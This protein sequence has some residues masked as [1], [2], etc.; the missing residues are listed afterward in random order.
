MKYQ[1]ELNDEDYLRFNIFYAT[2]S[3]VGQHNVKMARLAFPL[4]CV[5]AVVIFMMAGAATT[6]IIAEGVVL[7]A[8]S[9]CW[10]FYLPKMME[11]SVKKISTESKPMEK[12][13]ITHILKLN[14]WT[15]RLLN[16]RVMVR[17]M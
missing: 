2:H 5:L 7:A 16:D 15:L 9:V 14:C 4:V 12:C 3:K 11:K 8:A 6:F 1:I 17:F 10:Q 13:L